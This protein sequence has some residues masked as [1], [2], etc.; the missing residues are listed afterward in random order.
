[1]TSPVSASARRGET[2]TYTMV[3]DEKNGFDSPDRLE[4]T[5][6]ALFVTR[7]YDFG[8]YNPPFPRTIH[9]P[10]VVPDYLPPGVTIDGVLKAT[11]DDLVREN[12]LTLIVE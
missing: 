2:V 4:L 12:R 3:I 6:T 8:T 5:A 1:M 9:Y 10:F 7:R 11:S